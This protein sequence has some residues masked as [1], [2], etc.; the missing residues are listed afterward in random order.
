MPRFNIQ[1]IGIYGFALV[2]NPMTG[3]I[4]NRKEF[5]PFETK[6]EL[7]QFYNGEKVEVYKDEGPNMFGGGV[8]NYTKSFRKNGP[9]EWMNPLMID[10]FDKPGYHGHGIFEV[11][12]RVEEVVKTSAAF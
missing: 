7:M 5:G 3:N 8:K 12:L 1:A 2:L 9:L 6:E 4:E 10:E 11:L